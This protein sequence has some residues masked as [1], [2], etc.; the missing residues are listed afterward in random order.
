MFRH[1]SSWKRLSPSSQ[2]SGHALIVNSVSTPIGS[3]NDTLLLRDGPN[4]GALKAKFSSAQPP[5]T[6]RR[7]ATTT[8]SYLNQQPAPPPHDAVMH[9][10]P[11][12]PLSFSIT[13]TTLHSHN[14]TAKW[15]SPTPRE[16]TPE[17]GG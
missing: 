7:A 8:T 11:C 13:T 3:R 5:P 14:Q 9:A 17:G 10:L 15:L 12:Y 1:L 6:T 2:S 16:D 4:H